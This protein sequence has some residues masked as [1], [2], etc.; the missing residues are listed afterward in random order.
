MSRNFEQQYK[1]NIAF[2]K[3]SFNEGIKKIKNRLYGE[4]GLRNSFEQSNKVEIRKVLALMDKKI[5]QG[6]YDSTR[7]DDSPNN[8]VREY[9]N[10]FDEV[11]PRPSVP[12][13]LYIDIQNTIEEFQNNIKAQNIKKENRERK[14]QQ[15][16]FLFNFVKSPKTWALALWSIS[17]Y[18][19]LNRFFGP[20]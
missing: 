14:N 9:L 5:D 6:I 15:L 1:I 16:S 11:I 3:D 13:N 12:E 18:F 8:V 19:I 4:K 7:D 20:V 17:L 2:R 10:L